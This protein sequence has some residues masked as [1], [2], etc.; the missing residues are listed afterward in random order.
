MLID[1]KAAL[2]AVAKGRTGSY[3]FRTT[4]GEVNASLLATGTVLRPLYVPCEDN[5]AD[6]P[7]RGRR[8]RPLVRRA[9]K[10]VR[11]CKQLWKLRHNCVALRRG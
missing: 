4:L 1:A 11:L 9:G 3:A 2:S 7:S 6:A 5:P 10:P 8:K